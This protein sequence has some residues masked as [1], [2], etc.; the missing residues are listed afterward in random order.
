MLRSSIIILGAAALPLAS[1]SVAQSGATGPKPVS[2]AEFQ[3]KTD[4]A[5]SQ[6]DTNKDGFLSAQEIQ[7]GQNSALQQVNALRQARM[8]AEF[9]QLDTNKDGQLSFQEFAAAAPSVKSAETPQQMLQKLDA[10]KDGKVSASEFST[11]RLA[12]FNK[13]DANKD[14]V[15]SVDEQ[16]K[17]AGQK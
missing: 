3:S 6:L 11:P 9:K 16:R 4:Q 17:A 13:L 5:F 1:A 12:V 14:G 15:V 2:R 7:V 8:Q 10:N